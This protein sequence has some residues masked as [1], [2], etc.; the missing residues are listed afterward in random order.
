MTESPT[1]FF[2]GIDSPVSI[3]SSTCELPSVTSPSTGILSPGLMT[4]VS[5]ASTSAVGTCDLDAGAKHGGHRRGEVHQRTDRVRGAGARAHLQPVAQQDEDQ[6]HGR[7]FEEHL[8]LVEERGA[9]AEQ[10]ARADREDDQR[11]HV[12]DPV[13]RGPPGRDQERPARIGD[14]PCGSDEQKE[15]S[16]HTERRREVAEHLAHR[17]V[18]EDRDGEHQGDQESVAHVVGHVLHRHAGRMTHVVHHVGLLVGRRTACP[19]R[20]A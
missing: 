7:R 5:P 3:D 17:R 4:T 14:G 6:Q 11:R 16:I 15:L 19:C 2:T 20:A 13:A 1:T 10:V 8:A 12:G 18:Q 9:H